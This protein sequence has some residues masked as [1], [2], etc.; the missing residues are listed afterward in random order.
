MLP[1]PTAID[2]VLFAIENG[3]NGDIVVSK[4][5]ASTVGDIAKSM[6]EIFNSNVGIETVG[7]REGEKMH[8][9]LVTQ[10]ELMKSEDS[11][12]YFKIHNL[13]KFDYD[14]YFTHGKE[15]HIPEM[16][17]TSENTE[18]LDLVATKKL[19]LSLPEIQE[20]LS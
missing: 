10:E 15:N 13:M 6:L 5:P 20:V 12:D 4:S 1:L 8:E 11:G 19:I 9:T 3:E 14:D 16:G 17:Y 7:I 2:L 18:R